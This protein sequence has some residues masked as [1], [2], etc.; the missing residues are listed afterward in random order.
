MKHLILSLVL[1][2]SCNQ[3]SAQILK[4]KITNQ[5]GEPI[6]YSTVYIQERKQGTTANVKGDYEI[7]LPAG[8]YTVIY[9]SLGYE[10]IFVNVTLSDKTITKNIILPVQYYQIPEV[11]IT[12]SGE[13]PAYIIMRKVIG[14]APYYLNNI[15]NYKAE[16]YLKGNLVVQNIPRLLQKSMKIASDN[17]STSISAGSKSS[18]EDKLIKEGDVFVMESFNEIEFNAPDKYFQKVISFNSTFPEQ[19]DDISPMDFIQASFYQPILVDVAISPL[20]PN[21]FSHYKFKYLGAS[22]Q[23]NYTINKIEVIPKRKSQQVFEGTIFIIED[24]WCLHSVDLTNENLV[25]KIKVQQLYIPVQDD[26]WMPVSHKFD[27]NISIMGFKAD[28]GYGGSVKYLDVKPNLALAKPKTISV[29]Y[30]GRTALPAEKTD[31]VKSKTKQQIEKIL[32]K[33]DMSNRDMVKLS[34]LMEKESNESLP[35]SVRNKLEISDKTTH[36]VEKDAGKK[37]S[38]YWAAVRPVPLSEL[39]MKSIR[40]NDS[41]K[42]LSTKREI[43]ND[44]IPTEGG[45]KN[46]M[47]GTRAQWIIFGHTWR[48]TSGFYFTHNGFIDKNSIAFNTVD[49]FTYGLSFR[50]SKAFKDWNSIS[51]Y[52]DFRYAFSRKEFMWRVNGTYSFNGLKQRQIYLRTGMYSKDIG[53]GGGINPLL[54]SITS[55]F[56]E[57]NYLKLY[58]SKYLIMGFKTEIVNGLNLDISSNIDDRHVLENTTDYS[59][60]RSSNVYTDNIPDNPYLD[61]ASNPVNYMTDM[62]HADINI[63]LT[64][65]PFMKYRIN[66]GRKVPRGSTWP[67]LSLAWQHGINEL[68]QFDNA[69]RHYDMIRFEAYKRYDD[70]GAF[71]ELRWRIRAGGFLDNRNVPFYDFFHF[72]PQPPLVLLD[73]YQ[74]AF[75]LPAY[76]SISTPEAFGEL[77]IKYTTPYLLI[78]LLP[79]ISNTLMRENVSLSWLGTK[80]NPNYTEL[81]YSISEIFFLAELGVYVG[82]EDLGYKSIGGKLILKFN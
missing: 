54:N 19:G 77:H 53:T 50:F 26:I 22:L 17:E 16:V 48:D 58:D 7:K 52:P 60:I 35:D 73:D 33:E 47:F 34:R 49:G 75:M 18:N 6:Q 61:S 45:K 38:I 4:G 36:V 79:G 27:I 69:V 25:G 82:F 57:K 1:L 44:T 59:F 65:T 80:N 40:K 12:A 31:T 9:Q 72:N 67:T 76:Y 3:L 37:D 71:S 21:A 2:I 13:D 39:E 74:D 11:R 63:K 64:Y 46:N 30:T 43:K 81:G 68:S 41:I 51:V 28:A 10:P 15:S 14:M 24:L 5:A 8:K 42:A 56:F 55:L 29:D 66:N 78:K 20:S 23:G 70:I 62:R 32:V